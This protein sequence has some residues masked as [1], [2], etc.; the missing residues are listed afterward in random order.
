ML[1]YRPN[2]IGTTAKRFFKRLLRGSV[3]EPRNT[4]TDK[5]LNY[6]VAHRE[7]IPDAI[8]VTGRNANNLTEKNAQLAE[9]HGYEAT[10]VREREMRK[11]TLIKQA[12]GVVTAHAAAPYLFNRG[13]H[14]VRAQ[15]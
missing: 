2:V 14:L 10:K 13:S 12:Q 11:F 1:I 4:V 5:L 7:V 8:H 3:S 15:Y 6:P 9:F